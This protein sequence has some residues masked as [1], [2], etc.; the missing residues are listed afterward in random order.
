MMGD[1]RKWAVAVSTMSDLDPSPASGTEA[2]GGPLSLLMGSTAGTCVP[3][4]VSRC[5]V[6]TCLQSAAQTH[7]CAGRCLAGAPEGRSHS[8]IPSVRT[9]GNR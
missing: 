5:R 2:A 9:A 3:L 7:S 8:C 6:H 4:H 1:I